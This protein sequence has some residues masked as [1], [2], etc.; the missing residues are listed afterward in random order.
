MTR[1]T[2]PECKGGIVMS[3]QCKGLSSYIPFLKRDAFYFLSGSK[4]PREMRQALQLSMAPCR[5]Y[6]FLFMSEKQEY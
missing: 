5:G 4:E 3:K 2:F 1:I 6:V